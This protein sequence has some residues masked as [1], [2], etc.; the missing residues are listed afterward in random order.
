MKWTR[1]LEQFTELALVLWLWDLF[2][3]PLF[4]FRHSTR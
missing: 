2:G 4:S 3:R 1:P